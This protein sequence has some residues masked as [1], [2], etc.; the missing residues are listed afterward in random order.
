MHLVPFSGEGGCGA[1]QSTG[2]CELVGPGAL[3]NFLPGS[4]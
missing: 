4:Q 2:G 3:G 1:V